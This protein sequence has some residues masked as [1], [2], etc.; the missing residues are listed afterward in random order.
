MS[1]TLTAV[2][3]KILPVTSASAWR[4]VAPGKASLASLYDSLG[5]TYALVDTHV[6]L[7]NVKSAAFYLAYLLKV[8]VHSLD[9]MHS[10]IPSRVTPIYRRTMAL[11]SERYMKRQFYACVF[12]DALLIRNLRD[13]N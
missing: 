13:D 2:C 4:D 8:R 7:L 10:Y 11:L 3:S 12:E 6:A 5:T 9:M 1:Q